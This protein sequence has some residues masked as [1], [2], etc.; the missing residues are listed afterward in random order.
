[1]AVGVVSTVLTRGVSEASQI[2]S[3]SAFNEKLKGIKEC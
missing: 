2:R 1:M 3:S